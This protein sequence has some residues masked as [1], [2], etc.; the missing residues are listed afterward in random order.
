MG[1]DKTKPPKN[2][3]ILVNQLRKLRFY[4]QAVL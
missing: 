3:P 4:T 2:H 1:A